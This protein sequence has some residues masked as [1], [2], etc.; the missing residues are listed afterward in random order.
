MR[1]LITAG[2]TREHLDPVRFLSNA[3]TGRIGLALARRAKELGH[4]VALVLGPTPLEP[5]QVD[6]LVRV[7]TAE[8]MHAAVEARFSRCDGLIAAAAPCDFR[9]AVRSPVKLKKGEGPPTPALEPTP[10]ILAEMARRRTG[11]LLVGF[12][13]ETE[14]LEERARAKLREKGLDLIVANGPEAMG[15]GHQDALLITADGETTRLRDVTKDSLA[16]AILE[17]LARR[18]GLS[19]E[20]DAGP[21][22][23]HL[24]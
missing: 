22:G 9:P 19:P 4:R 7:T 6:E 17:A 11:Q 21:G 24:Q 18:A 12:C 1:L 3:A 16:G 20:R 13:L 2:P 15:A 5:P 8:E 23:H 10:D 14:D